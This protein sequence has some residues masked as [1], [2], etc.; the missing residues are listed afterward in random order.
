MRLM[1][2]FLIIFVFLHG[3]IFG[4]TTINAKG[5]KRLGPY[6]N[7]EVKNPAK[8]VADF[9]LKGWPVRSKLPQ[10]ARESKYYPYGDRK[11]KTGTFTD[12]DIQEVST[13]SGTSCRQSVFDFSNMESIL[14]GVTPIYERF[15]VNDNGRRDNPAKYCQCMKENTKLEQGG[16]LTAKQL[17]A[18]HDFLNELK[19]DYADVLTAN[20]IGKYKRA[21]RMQRALVDNPLSQRTI[22]RYGNFEVIAKKIAPRKN[23]YEIGFSCISGNINTFMQKRVE[24]K[25]CTD[26]GL[27]YLNAKLKDHTPRNSS[28]PE[29]MHLPMHQENIYQINSEAHLIKG[30]SSEVS[31]NVNNNLNIVIADDWAKTGTG[32]APEKVNPFSL[33]FFT[34]VF[35][36]KDYASES[37]KQKIIADNKFS[38][39]EIEFFKN[40]HKQFESDRKDFLVALQKAQQRKSSGRLSHEERAI[41]DYVKTHNPF[42]YDALKKKENPKAQ[43]DYINGILAKELGILKNQNKD[44]QLTID[45]AW[46]SLYHHGFVKS[47][48]DCAQA[49]DQLAQVCEKGSQNKLNASFFEDLIN[50]MGEDF[51]EELAD[52][53]GVAVEVLQ[54]NVGMVSCMA[55]DGN[56]DRRGFCVNDMEWAITDKS[57]NKV[58]NDFPQYLCADKSPGFNAQLEKSILLPDVAEGR[59]P[60]Q[61]SQPSNVYFQTGT[62][63]ASKTNFSKTDAFQEMVNKMASPK[64]TFNT[65]SS[66]RRNRSNGM[67]DENQLGEGRGSQRLEDGP[68]IDHNAGYF[69]AFNSYENSR[70][71]DEANQSKGNN[72]KSK[73]ATLQVPKENLSDYEKMLLEKLNSLEEKQKKLIEKYES[74]TKK[75]EELE[76]KNL[77]NDKKKSKGKGKPP[78]MNNVDQAE[79][80]RL[81]A[82]INKLKEALRSKNNN[83]SRIPYQVAQTEKYNNPIGSQYKAPQREFGR[84]TIQS[85]SYSRAANSSDLSRLAKVAP[86]RPNNQSNRL[87]SIQLT[88]KE[89]STAIQV[90]SEGQVQEQLAKNGGRPVLVKLAN[91]VYR[92]EYILDQKTGRPKKDKN[93]QPLLKK[94]L[95][96]I[97]PKMKGQNNAKVKKKSK[98]QRPAHR[99][100]KVKDLNS[101]IEKA[102]N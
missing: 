27:N 37:D 10:S 22:D 70:L 12:I 57:M 63:V 85:A 9:T 60:S 6:L 19:D 58:V 94:V 26:Q 28:N 17:K 2:H 76:K 99:R 24:N 84:R 69:E 32:D 35:G 62:K 44:R 11:L 97:R 21:A 100:I 79:F 54:H 81:H 55:L 13:S 64:K 78:K 52:K 82:E 95:V 77:A 96:R 34:T 101:L 53:K 23:V 5:E 36:Q 15:C 46:D 72:L 59:L 74:K 48:N 45:D 41:I 29:L 73:E 18:T 43:L 42:I 56:K 47:F 66:P 93:G 3:Q 87:R 68:I 50:W 86:Q 16:K 39:K 71:I 65:D 31:Q 33:N 1:S 92:Y 40:R 89:I 91:E 102:K 7:M 38:D 61:K 20:A 4:Q 98:V 14:G 30:I 25:S 49:M 67:S 8:D 75:E 88:S 80:T 51:F 90:K 83:A